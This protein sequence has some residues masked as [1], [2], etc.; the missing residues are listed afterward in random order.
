VT[1]I[2]YRNQWRDR[3]GQYYLRSR[4]YDT[5]TGRFP[6]RDV[7]RPDAF[8]S[9]DRNGY[10]YVHGNPI[11]SW[12][13]TGKLTL[14]ETAVVSGTIATLTSLVTST[15]HAFRGDRVTFSG[16]LTDAAVSFGLGF[17]SAPIGTAVGGLIAK[18]TLWVVNSLIDSLL[19]DAVSSVFGRAT[20]FYLGQALKN[21][22]NSGTSAAVSSAVKTFVSDLGDLW[23][24]KLTVK[25]ELDRVYHAGLRGFVAGA[26]VGSL[27]PVS[28][29]VPSG[30]LKLA[31]GETG[32][33]V[34]IPIT[35]LQTGGILG[36]NM[37][38]AEFVG[39]FI[40]SI[41]KDAIKNNF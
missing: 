8:N 15:Y 11:N 14:L 12:D 29:S 26:L 39:T 1:S 34:Y 13:P 32:T 41:F 30:E 16:I 19:T 3:S 31:P 24:G 37:E 9:W 38:L 25:D 36:A 22:V 40:R 21:G 33:I 23:N 4:Y 27:T 18:G 10:G 28:A 17:I 35:Q 20:A 7:Y 2:L 5:V 6:S